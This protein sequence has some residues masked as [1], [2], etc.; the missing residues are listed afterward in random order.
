MATF[1]E[2]IFIKDKKKDGTIPISIRVT[3]N[4]KSRYIPTNIYIKESQLTRTGKLK[5][6]HIQDI[7]DKRLKE[8]RDI[9]ADINIVAKDM[10]VDEFMRLLKNKSEVVDFFAFADK[11]LEKYRR[12]KERKGTLN[13]YISVIKSFKKYVGKDKL[14]FDEMKKGLIQSYYD[15]LLSRLTTRTA[16]D[17]ITKLKTI[18]NAAITKLNDEE[19]GI[20]VVKYHC[21][22]GLSKETVEKN[23][24][25]SFETVAQ[26]QSVI[27][28]PYVKRPNANFAKDMFI[29][30]FLLNG[31]NME[32][33]YRITKNQY[34]GGF[35]LLSRHK[36]TRICGK[37]AETKIKV[38]DVADMIIKKYSGD[39]KYLIKFNRE[40]YNHSYTNSYIGYIFQEVG[41][42]EKDS[43]DEDKKK[44]K[45]KK[46]GEN[47]TGR[48]R[49][50]YT[51]NTAR[52]S[53]ASFCRNEC[54]IPK[55]ITD[56]MLVHSEKDVD[57][58]YKKPYQQMWE[59]NE[60]LYAL[61][62]W[63]KY[64]QMLTETTK[65]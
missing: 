60:K 49:H 39:D 56:L 40:D 47:A 34:S 65:C 57:V 2:Y 61:F 36:V 32:D 28:C 10:S 5:D 1:K 42:R 25:K 7:L 20:A 22:D 64:K 29:L 54:G 63:A 9:S 30:S 16:N 58:Y 43:K 13:S 48:K 46:K 19:A 37:N 27:D 4:R 62:D 50:K 3:H 31:I 6:K 59:A 14:P 44:G 23:Q 11:E 18:H 41:L 24:S 21:F 15:D 35:L 17:Y 51:F 26:M 33:I 45:N 53:M 8:L 52:H 12:D 55:D 38:L